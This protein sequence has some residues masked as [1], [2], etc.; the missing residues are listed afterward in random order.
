MASMPKLSRE[1]L[2]AKFK[3]PRKILDHGHIRIVDVMGDDAAVVQSA[4]VSY[5]LGVSEHKWEKDTNP[6]TAAVT[7]YV[8][9]TCGQHQTG[10]LGVPEPGHCA[11]AD[12]GL[13]RY[14][15]RH[16]HTTPFEMCEIKLHVK[17][18]VFV[19]RQWIRH[20]TANVNEMSGRYSILPAEFYVPEI[21]R[22]QAQ[23]KSNK[24]GSGEQIAPARAARIAAEMNGQ[25]LVDFDYYSNWVDEDGLARELA[26]INLPVSTYTEWYWK[27]DLHNLLH[28]LSLRM[29]PHAQYE[30]RV[31][32]DALAEMVQQW[33]PQTWRAFEDYRLNASF[34]SAQESG[35][36][37]QLVAEAMTAR[38]LLAESQGQTFS[39]AAEMKS[40]ADSSQLGSK[41]ERAAF[42]RSMGIL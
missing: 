37:T 1:E 40:L 21:E 36:I 25:A 42:W 39:Y 5:G 6:E 32:A 33:V 10:L 17:L 8:C 15:M 28:F 35:L 38:E 7:S 14:L 13:I 11:K 3:K 24:Q 22:V 4:R 31:Y 30:I 18:P 9:L 2:I 23:S 16:R 12:E 20:R 19:A 26:R 41:R 29:H 27:I 34:F